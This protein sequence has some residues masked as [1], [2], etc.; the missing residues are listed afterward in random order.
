MG[1]KKRLLRKDDLLTGK[2]EGEVEQ[3]TERKESQERGGVR[4]RVISS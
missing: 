3:K 1:K 2:G 4:I